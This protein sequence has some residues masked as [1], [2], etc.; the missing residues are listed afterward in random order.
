MKHLKGRGLNHL[1]AE[2]LTWVLTRQ[3]DE[4]YREPP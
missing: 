4:P 3:V 2:G 1:G